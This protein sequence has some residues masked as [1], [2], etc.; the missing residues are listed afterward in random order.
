M[1]HRRSSRQAG[2][3]SPPHRIA[4]ATSA[5]DAPNTKEGPIL[6]RQGSDLSDPEVIE[7]CEQIVEA[8]QE[9]IAQME[10]ILQ[11]DDAEAASGQWCSSWSEGSGVS[12]GAPSAAGAAPLM[13]GPTTSELN[14]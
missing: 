8:Q 10:G 9:E 6:V 5:A 12:S 11:R 2:C 4:S 7:L 3:V 13:A 14:R 1:A